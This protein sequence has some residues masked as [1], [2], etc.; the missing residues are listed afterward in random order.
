MR[1]NNRLLMHCGLAAL[2]LVLSGCG[3]P[4][5]NVEPL[6]GR[7]AEITYTKKGQKRVS[8]RIVTLQACQVRRP[9]KG[10][11]RIIDK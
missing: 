1:I 10:A 4:Q 6:A 11:A 3:T 8:P 5:T 7:Y 9:E 2:C